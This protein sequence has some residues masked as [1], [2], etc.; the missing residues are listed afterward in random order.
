MPTAGIQGCAMPQVLLALNP[1]SPDANELWLAV[2]SESGTSEFTLTQ[3]YQCFDISLHTLHP[4][5][6]EH[7][8]L[9]NRGAAKYN[10]LF[11]ESVPHL[12]H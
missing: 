3:S 10:M 1:N 9:D 7:H 8:S 5:V 12:E 2:G 4:N 6:A 11:H